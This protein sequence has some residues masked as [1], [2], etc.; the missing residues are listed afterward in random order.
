MGQ[1][2]T[3]DVVVFLSWLGTAVL[4]RS[5]KQELQFI[6]DRPDMVPSDMAV[7]SPLYDVFSDMY[8][9]LV[10]GNSTSDLHPKLDYCD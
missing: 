1:L 10:A 3:S 4:S 8:N 5:Q 2:S 7:K 6:Q 9:L